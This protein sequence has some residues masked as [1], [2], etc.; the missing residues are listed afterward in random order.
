MKYA[1]LLGERYTPLYFLNALVAGGFAVSSYMYLYWLCK[2]ELSSLPTFTAI[3][4]LFF[5]HGFLLPTL[6]VLFLGLF[7]F[8]SIL[9]VRLLVWNFKNFAQWKSLVPCKALMA[10]KDK[11]VLLTVPATLSVS[12][13]LVLMTGLMALPFALMSRIFLFPLVF[14]WLIY[15]TKRSIQIY[16]RFLAAKIDD[17]NTNGANGSNLGQLIAVFSFILLALPF[18]LIA[19]NS[20]QTLMLFLCEIVSISLMFLAVLICLIHFVPKLSSFLIAPLSAETTPLFWFYGG[21]LSVLTVT[22]FQ[23]DG[24]LARAFNTSQNPAMVLVVCTLLIVCCGLLGFVGYTLL[25]RQEILL[26]LLQGKLYAPGLYGVLCPVLGIG[27]SY[28]Y[29]LNVAL[30]H[31]GFCAPYSVVHLLAHGPLVI[32]HL[33]A[34]RQLVIMNK[35]LFA[36]LPSKRTQPTSSSNPHK[37]AL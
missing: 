19:Q 22:Y 16:A 8:F 17:Q 5:Y 20:E 6:A 14:L 7:I 13:M 31:S 34:F 33:W 18:A 29:F 35:H 26:P 1:R 27:L 9:H 24:G 30:L 12:T 2:I 11:T 37:Q 10:A 3:Y 23:I 4:T 15:M 28:G 21:I 32:M 36:P 25:H